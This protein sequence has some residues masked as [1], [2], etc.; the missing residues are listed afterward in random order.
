MRRQAPPTRLSLPPWGKQNY[1]DDCWQHRNNAR[2]GVQ[3]EMKFPFKGYADIA[4]SSKTG[5][6]IGALFFAF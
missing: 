4:P 3:P 2:H 6:W 1:Y 5:P